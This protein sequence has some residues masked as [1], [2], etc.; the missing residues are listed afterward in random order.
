[1]AAVVL[2][3]TQLLLQLPWLPQHTP[4]TVACRP[5]VTAR[6]LV[7]VCTQALATAA[8]ANVTVPA[9]ARM[10]PTTVAP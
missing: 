9:C 10:S 6:L 2:L 3:R 1:M 8:C 4:A 7:S 5:R